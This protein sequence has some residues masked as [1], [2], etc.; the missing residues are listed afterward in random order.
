MVLSLIC[1]RID[2]ENKQVIAWFF[3][4]DNSGFHSKSREE[5]KIGRFSHTVRSNELDRCIEDKAYDKV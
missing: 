4:A 1:S 5:G 2:V 3:L